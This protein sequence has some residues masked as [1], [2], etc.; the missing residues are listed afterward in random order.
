MNPLTQLQEEAREDAVVMTVPDME[1]LIENDQDSP[2]FLY[3]DDAQYLITTAYLKGLERLSEQL[4]ELEGEARKQVVTW[5]NSEDWDG[6]TNDGLY[7]FIQTISKKRI[8]IT[9][10]ITNIKEKQ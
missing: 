4:L 6:T 9:T 2:E 1:E 5:E 8:A 7:S 3:L 10:E